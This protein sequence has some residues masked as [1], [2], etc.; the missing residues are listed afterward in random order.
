[1]TFRAVVLALACGGGLSQAL[2]PLLASYSP[3]VRVPSLQYSYIPNAN[4]FHRPPP[5]PSDPVTTSIREPDA[6][7]SLPFYNV[8][9][10]NECAALTSAHGL[11]FFSHSAAFGICQAHDFSSASNNYA[12]LLAPD[13]EFP[14]S[15]PM[16]PAFRLAIA[17][18]VFDLDACARACQRELA[19]VAYHLSDNNCDLYGPTANPLE[20]SIAGWINQPMNKAIK[21]TLPS[22][23]PRSAT[24]VHFYIVAHEDDNILFM[25]N[26]YHWSIREPETKVVFIFATAGDAS[27]GN[28]WREAREAGAIAASQ[29]WVEHFGQFSAEPAFD[30]VQVPTL[31]GTTHKIR[32]VAVGNIVH[33]FFSIDEIGFDAVN[34]DRNAVA[35]MDDPTVPYS[36]RNDLKETLTFVLAHESNGIESV[37][38]NTQMFNSTDADDHKLHRATGQLVYDVVNDHPEW[39]SCMTRR[40]YYDY[41]RW[42]ALVNMESPVVEVQRYAWMR[43]SQAIYNHNASVVF[44]SY[45]SK[46]AECT[47][48]HCSPWRCCQQKYN[49]VLSF[50][51]LSNVMINTNSVTKL[52]RVSKQCLVDTFPFS[53][54]L[55]HS[56]RMGTNVSF[57]YVF[58]SNDILTLGEKPLPV[59]LREHVQKP[60]W[61]KHAWKINLKIRI[62]DGI[63]RIVVPMWVQRAAAPIREMPIL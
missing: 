35:P 24:R 56:P 10:A 47:Q 43:L 21:S 9:T 46:A 54:V 45:L 62:I 18:T 53:S 61:I 29:V 57:G 31:N 13:G 50:L 16:L 40:F 33:Y 19:C 17:V 12:I 2:S 14:W 6:S 60:N 63:S 30:T 23:D 48:R 41:Q 51:P 39:R 26:M 3:D 36:G 8:P 22:F 11:T 38:V 37:E 1:M 52:L 59:V 34:T 58:P 15:Q 32:T 44:W 55:G 7:T 28:P 4:W 5:Y 42:L 25:A 27:L 20:N 49:K